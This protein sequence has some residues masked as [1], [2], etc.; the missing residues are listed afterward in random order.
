M[1]PPLQLQGYTLSSGEHAQL[2]DLRLATLDEAT[3]AASLD[4]HMP[5]QWRWGWTATIK[6]LGRD[7]QGNLKAAVTCRGPQLAQP[8]VRYV[9]LVR[10]RH[11]PGGLELP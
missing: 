6:V 11:L 1:L 9:R 10:R 4:S 7:A 5:V 3:A 2:L 8:Y